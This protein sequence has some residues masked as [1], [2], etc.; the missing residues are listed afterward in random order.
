MAARTLNGAVSNDPPG[1]PGATP[2]VFKSPYSG[3]GGSAWVD[4]LSYHTRGTK[5]ENKNDKQKT[6]SIMT[7]TMT[8]RTAQRTNEISDMDGNPSERRG[9]VLRSPPGTPAM[10]E[11]RDFPEVSDILILEK[12]GHAGVELSERVADSRDRKGVPV[13]TN[14][15]AKDP[16]I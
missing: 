16:E 11:V 3:N 5:M 6:K 2:A 13:T 7:K 10:R 9:M 14:R 4:F 1:A 15:T 8:T 12:Q